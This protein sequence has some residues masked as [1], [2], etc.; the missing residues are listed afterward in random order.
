MVQVI[1]GVKGSGKTK[2]LIQAIDEAVQKEKGSMV[3]IEKGNSLTFNINYR[4]RL[5]DAGEYQIDNYTLLRGFISGLQAGNFDITHIFIDNLFKISGASD[6]EKAVE[7]LNWCEAFSNK[8]KLE[9]T[10]SVT[11]DPTTA[12]KGI[13]K[14]L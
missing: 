4:V 12:P 5:C 6:M 2:R 13:Q 8:N 11:G 9:F 10:I 1:L 14:F 3:C 7:F